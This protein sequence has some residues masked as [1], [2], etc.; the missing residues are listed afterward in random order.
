MIGDLGCRHGLPLPACAR[1]PAATATSTGPAASGTVKALV[2]A[3]PMTGLTLIAASQPATRRRDWAPSSVPVA[4]PSPNVCA[5]SATTTA[6]DPA[7]AIA[8]PSKKR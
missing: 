3:A 2:T 1:T 8:E 5:A 6:A 4:R 7:S